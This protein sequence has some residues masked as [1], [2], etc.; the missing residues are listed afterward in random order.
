MCLASCQSEICVLY[1]VQQRLLSSTSR[2]RTASFAGD[3]CN[4]PAAVQK[5]V[6][7]RFVGAQD[8]TDYRI[9]TYIVASPMVECS[10]VSKHRTQDMSCARRPR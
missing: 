7:I 10:Q 6:P 3:F 8:V 5:D 1:I 4:A 9:A 2:I